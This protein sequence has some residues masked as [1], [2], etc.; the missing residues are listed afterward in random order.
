MDRL[1]QLALVVA[2]A[3]PLPLATSAPRQL[4]PA[5]ARDLQSIGV[6]PWQIDAFLAQPD[7]DEAAIARF[8][9]SARDLSVD[10]RPV[11]EFRSARN[12]FYFNKPGGS[13]RWA[14]RLRKPRPR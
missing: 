12:L 6:L 3:D 4:P 5:V 2:S 10:D 8:R 13:T 1:A 7:L 11:L 14:D 9:A